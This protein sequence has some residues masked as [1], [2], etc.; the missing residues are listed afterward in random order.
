MSWHLSPMDNPIVQVCLKLGAVHAVWLNTH[1]PLPAAPHCTAYMYMPQYLEQRSR[2]HGYAALNFRLL[3]KGRVQSSKLMPSRPRPGRLLLDVQANTLLHIS[4][5]RNR[6]S[7]WSESTIL[8]A[9]PG[10]HLGKVIQTDRPGPIYKSPEIRKPN[11][12]GQASSYTKSIDPP[13]T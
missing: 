2:S 10:A 8:G 7:G 6:Q 11:F 12:S 4:K 13:L 1:L 9:L 3:L 5:T